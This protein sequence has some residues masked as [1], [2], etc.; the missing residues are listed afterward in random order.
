MVVSI[1]VVIESVVDTTVVYTVGS[2]VLVGDSMD[3]TTVVDNG[4]VTVDSLLVIGN[5]VVDTVVDTEVSILV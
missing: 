1:V 4:V 3:V 2:A 5:S